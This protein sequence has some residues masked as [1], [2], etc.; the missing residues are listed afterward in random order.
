MAHLCLLPVTPPCLKALGDSAN[1][2]HWA[3]KGPWHHPQVEKHH[4]ESADL[5]VTTYVFYSVGI[6]RT[7]SPGDS[8]SQVIL[9]E[10]L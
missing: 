5:P 8:I 6:F 7:S 10:L 3:Q 2:G 4:A 9:R 1:S